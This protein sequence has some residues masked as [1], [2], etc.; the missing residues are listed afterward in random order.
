LGWLATPLDDPFWL[1]LAMPTSQLCD[2]PFAN[3][4]VAIGA[5]EP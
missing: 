5:A 3:E 4:T 2:R 1:A